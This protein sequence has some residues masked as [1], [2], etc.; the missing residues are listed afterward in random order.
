V[1]IGR[2][3]PALDPN[4]YRTLMLFQLAEAHYRQPG[5]ARLLE[6][7]SPP[8]YVRPKSA[9]LVAL[10]QSGDLDYAFLYASSA[11]LAGL[12][13]LMLPPEIDL[14]SPAQAAF[15]AQARVWLPGASAGARDSVAFR[16]EPILYALTIP[17]RAPH[18]ATA[19]A[20]VKFVLSAEGQ[21][22]LRKSGFILP[23]KPVLRGDTSFARDLLPR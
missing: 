14:G 15:Y 23:A 2:A 3:D 6:A 20:F 16:G 5:L 11:Q 9:D 4:G 19:R 18:P 7:A 17:T 10:L 13:A 12:R 8:R 21:A 1:R 22:I